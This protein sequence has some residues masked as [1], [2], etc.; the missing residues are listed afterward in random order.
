M[1][2][3][4]PSRERDVDMPEKH[5]G[6]AGTGELERSLGLVA[7]SLSRWTGQCL[8]AARLQDIDEF[9]IRILLLIGAGERGKTLSDVV[10]ALCLD[11][12]HKVR[13]AIGKLVKKRYLQDSP[14]NRTLFYRTTANGRGACRRYAAARAELFMACLARDGALSEDIAGRMLSLRRL[15]CVFDLASRST[16]LPGGRAAQDSRQ[17]CSSP[18]RT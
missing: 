9:E 6:D 16:I 13:Y 18:T 12:S 15:A 2:G 7:A 11:D 14:V 17:A 4:R 10:F 3:P 8:A 1:H 5:G